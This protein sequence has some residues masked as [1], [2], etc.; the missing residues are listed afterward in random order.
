MTVGISVASPP[1]TQDVAAQFLSTMTALSGVVTDFEKGSQVRTLAESFGSVVELQGIW[2]N[3][4]AFQA[5]MYSAM[6]V[7]NI[8]PY[9]AFPARGTVMFTTSV[10]SAFNITQNVTI[11]SGTIVQTAGG[12]QFSTTQTVTLASGTSSVNV[13]I[14]A[15]VG[16]TTG[17]VVSGSIKQIITG[18]IYPLAVINSAATGGGTDPEQLSQTLARFSAT[19]NSIGL[20]SPVAVANAAL[21]VTNA[22]TSE[23]VLYSTC[24]EGWVAA[25][26]GAGS[27]TAGFQI[28]IDN[29]FGTAG[30]GLVSAVTSKLNG[31]QAGGFVGYRP[32][33]VPY[34]VLPVT[35]TP[36]N[37]GVSGIISSLT[38]TG[39]VSGL[40]MNAVNSYLSLPFGGTVQQAPLAQAVGNSILG[41]TTSLTVGLYASGSS[42][43]VTG[44]GVSP[45][46]RI[47][48]GT[49]TMSL[50]SG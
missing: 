6:S 29:G 7:F 26:S 20:S 22:A 33:G 18:L 31:N 23:V 8:T 36:V 11:S 39:I 10:G 25:G 40:I 47:V 48:L 17:N 12:I 46:G 9:P 4:I 19:V 3:T 14:V 41:L 45:Y 37:V 5:L 50:S 24:Y 28:F 16:G 49:L 21:G 32:A 38:T 44:I 2:S 35:G 43:A 30:S 1:N 42:I 27:G 15:V 34:A 13:P